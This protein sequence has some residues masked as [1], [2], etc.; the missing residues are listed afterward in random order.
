MKEQTKYGHVANDLVTQ[1]E[2]QE[3]DELEKVKR[4][5]ESL[6]QSIRNRILAG[7]KVEPGPCSV[8]ISE[9]QTIQLT[10]ATIRKL[11][12]TLSKDFLAALPQRQ[13]LRMSLSP[14]RH[15]TYKAEPKVVFDPAR[16]KASEE[17][18]QEFDLTT[19]V[20]KAA[21]HILKKKDAKSSSSTM[22][23]YVTDDDDELE[24]HGK[25][26]RLY[27]DDLEIQG[28]VPAMI[29]ESMD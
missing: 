28:E 12:G 26:P 25:V 1:D 4:K 7:A 8:H 15:K 16:R 20:L 18:D 24:E 14:N 22:G 2:L 3:L 10:I 11:L 29:H 19:F 21:I 27:D 9:S 23:D 6:R 17:P 5:A 13:N